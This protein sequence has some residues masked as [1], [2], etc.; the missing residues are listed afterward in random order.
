METQSPNVFRQ[1]CCFQRT[2]ENIPV[3][4]LWEKRQ[5]KRV[6]SHFCFSNGCRRRDLFFL[7]ANCHQADK[8]QLLRRQTLDLD[9]GS[10]HGQPALCRARSTSEDDGLEEI[11]WIHGLGGKS[12]QELDG[13]VL[14]YPLKREKKSF[15]WHSRRIQKFCFLL[16]APQRP[17]V[18]LSYA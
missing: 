8:N 14:R 4:P 6:I 1:K 3:P 15:F 5:K 11:R 18:F 13:G 16:C 10:A 12:L 17:I 2:A 7:V 9:I